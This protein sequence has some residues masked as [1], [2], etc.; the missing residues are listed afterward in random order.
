MFFVLRKRR[1]EAQWGVY[2]T[3]RQCVCAC[4]LVKGCAER[5]ADS[6]HTLLCNELKAAV[7]NFGVNINDFF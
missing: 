4:V 6:V 5:S 3:G 7:G 1:D 2:D